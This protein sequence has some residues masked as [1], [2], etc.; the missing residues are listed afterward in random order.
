MLSSSGQIGQLVSLLY[1]LG[2]TIVGLTQSE[3]WGSGICVRDGMV[4]LLPQAL[5]N[6]TGRPDF[7]RG[8]P[9]VTI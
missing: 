6:Q 5:S 8:F 4:E 2:G 1:K 9:E 3:L 7:V